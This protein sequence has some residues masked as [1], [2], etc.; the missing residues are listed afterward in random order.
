MVVY[1]TTP[2]EFV[3]IV[4]EKSICFVPLPLLFL[5]VLSVVI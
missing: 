4:F 1:K 5:S 3:L 2:Q